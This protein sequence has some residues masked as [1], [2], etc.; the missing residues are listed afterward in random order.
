MG[1]NGMGRI[2]IRTS[3]KTLQVLPHALKTLMHGMLGW[4]TPGRAEVLA[5][6]LSRLCVLGMCTSH[7]ILDLGVKA[8]IVAGGF[9]TSGLAINGS[10][11]LGTRTSLISVSLRG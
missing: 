1:W 2:A 6:N 5:A 9:A 3:S 4:L 7:I 8:T 11:A 10:L